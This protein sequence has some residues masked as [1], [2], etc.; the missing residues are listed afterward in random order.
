MR[1]VRIGILVALEAA[2]Q[3][4]P[5]T[6]PLRA[7]DVVPH[8]KQTISWY[9]H[10]NA[11]EQTPALAS[12]V[13]LRDSIHSSALR[14]LQ[15]AFDFGR[16]AATLVETSG[17][18]EVPASTAAP[19]SQSL[20]QA[21][22]RAAAR[23]TGLQDRIKELD[24]S[25]EKARGAARETLRAQRST[26][27]AQLNLANQVRDTVNS[28]ASFTPTGGSGTLTAQIEEL[29]RSAPEAAH[30]TRPGAT[31]KVAPAPA[32]ATAAPPPL[33]P[34]R[35][36]TTG[37]I[38]LGTELFTLSHNRSQLRNLIDDTDELKNSLEGLRSPLVN[39]VRNIV[40]RSEALGQSAGTDDIQQL[41]ANQRDLDSLTAR[42]KQLSAVLV[43]L[44]EQ[45]IMLGAVRGDLNQAVDGLSAL[46]SDT[47]RY[48]LLRLG[49]LALAIG[50]VLVVST[51]W[52][53]VTFRYVHDE[54][55][56][57]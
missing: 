41:A 3:P 51:L 1:F 14:T 33:A 52:R 9:G 20:T 26:L 16:A 25:L 42:F 48:L 37:I 31:A 12:D 19:Q 11:L 32:P 4:Q 53:R 34:F 38:G 50:G 49:V 29:E 8:V 36:E 28:L 2:A 13:L 55:R 46:Y 10:V 44:G 6:A 27:Q 56:R 39:E 18:T 15:L 47:A 57:N 22:A 5:A 21:A 7:S 40:R 35:P 24:A 43:P 54:R 23:V 30:S 17:A 45:N